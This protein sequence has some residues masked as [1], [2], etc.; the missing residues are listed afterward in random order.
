MTALSIKQKLVFG[1]GHILNDLCATMW[2]TYLLL[3]F[4]EV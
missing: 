3:F 2:F 1:F 4:Q